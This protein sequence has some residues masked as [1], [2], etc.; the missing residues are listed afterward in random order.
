MPLTSRSVQR[1]FHSVTGLSQ[2]RI[3]QILRAPEAARL[4]EQ[5]T[6][7]TAVA[8]DSGCADQAHLTKALGLL[9]GQTPAQIVKSPKATSLY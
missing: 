3:R 8:H 4:L 5:R 9:L 6:S 2:N 1:R 7:I